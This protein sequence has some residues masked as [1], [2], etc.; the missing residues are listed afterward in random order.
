MLAELGRMTIRRR[1][2]GRIEL[3]LDRWA[4]V[5]GAAVAVGALTAA[6]ALAPVAGWLAV[7]AVGVA[8]VAGLIA[9]AHHRLV[10]DRHDGV[11][12]IERRIAG[13]GARSVIPLFHL[14]AVV[15]QRSGRGFVAA[16]ERRNGPPIVIDTA[17]RAAR[18]Y[19][20]VRAIAEVTEL[21]LIYDATQAS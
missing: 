5:L 4:R 18:L 1:T 21:R 20:L 13:V 16:I 7:I 17:D 9:T 6:I 19:Q 10:F 8:V 3:G 14:R 2:L 15:V 12:R 11:L